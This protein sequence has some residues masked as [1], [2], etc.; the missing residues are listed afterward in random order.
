MLAQIG[1]QKS[2]TE[3]EAASSSTSLRADAATDTIPPT[4]VGYEPNC[5]GHGVRTGCHVATVLRSTTV[6]ADEVKAAKRQLRCSRRAVQAAARKGVELP[7]SASATSEILEELAQLRL[8]VQTLKA[9][10]ARIAATASRTA[11]PGEL[12]EATEAAIP[13][14]PK[15]AATPEQAIT[16]EPPRSTVA[17]VHKVRQG[18]LG[19]DGQRAWHAYACCAYPLK[20][21]PRHHSEESL[22]TFLNQYQAR[23]SA[24]RAPSVRDSGVTAKSSQCNYCQQCFGSRNELFRHLR[25]VC[26]RGQLFMLGG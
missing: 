9:E 19:R 13:E 12:G 25:A 7:A 20:R 10:L 21:Q 22:Q 23:A 3:N 16:K 14:P 11:S 1:I 2:V 6:A 4:H 8:E 5:V 24:I 17:A 26:L 15:E 18:P